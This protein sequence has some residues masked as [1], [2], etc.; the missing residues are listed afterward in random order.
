MS[1]KWLHWLASKLEEAATGASQVLLAFHRMECSRENLVVRKADL[2]FHHKYSEL[3]NDLDR[4]EMHLLKEMGFICPVGHPP[5]LISAYLAIIEAQV[6][7]QEAWNLAN[8]SLRTSRCLRF[9]SEVIACRVMYAA[10][11]RFNVPLPENTRCGKSLM[12][13]NIKLMRFVEFWRFCTTALK[14]ST[15]LFART[16]YG[17]M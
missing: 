1:R 2:Y 11:R 17:R 12:L 7:S 6:L 15:S 9:K 3:K 14:R 5:N 13:K 8:D 4:I 10:T 16:N